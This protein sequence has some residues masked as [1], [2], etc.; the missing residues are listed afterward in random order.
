MDDFDVR[1][2]GSGDRDRDRVVGRRDD[3]D[4]RSDRSGDRGGPERGVDRGAGNV[5]IFFRERPQMIF[6]AGISKTIVFTRVIRRI[7][8]SSDPPLPCV[9]FIICDVNGLF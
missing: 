7:S 6:G 5:V 1:S 4:T 8:G 9:R 3:F 2:G